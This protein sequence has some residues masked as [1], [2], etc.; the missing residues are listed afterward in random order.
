MM[1][2]VVRALKAFRA[3]RVDSLRILP[4]PAGNAAGWRKLGRNGAEKPASA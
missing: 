1:V 2:G 4:L 3:L